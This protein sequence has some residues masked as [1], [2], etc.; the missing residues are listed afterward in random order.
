MIIIL[1]IIRKEDSNEFGENSVWNV[2]RR[3]WRSSEEISWLES[4]LRMANIG[5]WDINKKKGVDSD[6]PIKKCRTVAIIEG[7][8][9]MKFDEGSKEEKEGKRDSFRSSKAAAL[10]RV[11]GS[12]APISA[13]LYSVVVVWREGRLEGE[14][15]GARRLFTLWSNR[16][17]Y[18]WYIGWSVWRINPILSSKLVFLC[19]FVIRVL[20]MIIMEYI[21][22]CLFQVSYSNI[23]I[24]TYPDNKI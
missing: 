10:L 20:N 15:R 14:R 3:K 7:V 21:K 4:L 9:R 12:L 16:Y 11:I 17:M 19:Y 18:T 13:E 24:Y 2:G 6:A 22:R 8:I 1:S 5:Y 23:Y